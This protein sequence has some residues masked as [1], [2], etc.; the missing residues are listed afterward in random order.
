MSVFLERNRISEA[1]SRRRCPKTIDA[2]SPPTLADRRR[3][4]HFPRRHDISRFPVPL[5][6]PPSRRPV[7]DDLTPS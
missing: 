6:P 2:P 4:L 1:P 3:L 5:R 7:K